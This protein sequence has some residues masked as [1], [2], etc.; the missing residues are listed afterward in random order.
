[1]TITEQLI[2]DEGFKLRPYRC[3][4]G[5]LTIGVGRNLEDT[6]ISKAEALL[7][8]E[9]DIRSC[10]DRLK[11]IPWFSGLN[12]VRQE[13]LINMAFNLGVAGLMGFPR[14]MAALERGQYVLAS[15]E[16]LESKW[17]SQVPQRAKRLAEEMASGVRKG[18]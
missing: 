5:K 12:A 10:A 4:A 7:M 1:M 8:L 3:P 14:M 6:G 18:Q 11:G 2:A 17:A 15:Q 13:V 16:M 9:N